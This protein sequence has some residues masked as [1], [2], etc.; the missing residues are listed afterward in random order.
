MASFSTL[1]DS[2]FSLL[3]YKVSFT[4]EVE[5]VM[6]RNENV[7]IFLRCL[8]EILYNKFIGVVYQNFV[9]S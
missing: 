2:E 1:V 9:E 8:L 4:Y 5:M 6:S 7:V 3:K